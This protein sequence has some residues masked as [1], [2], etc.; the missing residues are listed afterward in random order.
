M[1][2]N[3]RPSVEETLARLSVEE[4]EERLEVSPLLAGG[5]VQ[6][7]SRTEGHCCTC[8][9]NPDPP[10]PDDGAPLPGPEG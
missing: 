5:D 9:V 8:K 1:G 2:E 7:V 4:L 6:D 3:R 10:E